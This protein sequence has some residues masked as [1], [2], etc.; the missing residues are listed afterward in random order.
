MKAYKVELVEYVHAN[1]LEEALKK[2][3]TLLGDGYIDRHSYEFTEAW[4]CTCEGDELGDH[5][6]MTEP[7][8]EE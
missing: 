3:D 8:E 5:I 6:C 4:E 1:S 2:F 7:N